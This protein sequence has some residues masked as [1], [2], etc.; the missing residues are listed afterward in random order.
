VRGR[1]GEPCARWRGW[2]NEQMVSGYSIR[3]ARQSEVGRLPDIERA[4]ARLFETY[5]GDL[6][7]DRHWLTE[8]KSIDELLTANDDGRLLVVVQDD[9]SVVGFAL[10]KDLGLFAHL[11]ELDVLPEH[12]R[13]GVGSA[14]LEAVC[15]WAYT[16][17]FSAVTLSTFRDVPWNA[18]F[19]ERRGFS[20]VAPDDLPPEL[21]R[22]VEA[23]RAKGLRTELRVIM[24]REV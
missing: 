11:E 18:P 7:V 13:K 16:H 10:L 23:E 4:A 21:V 9:G 24:Q 22:V 2:Q 8:V 17:G 12:G 19:Y 3:L 15:S 20:G 1:W 5:P 6:G 14:L